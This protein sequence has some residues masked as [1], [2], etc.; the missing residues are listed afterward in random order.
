MLALLALSAHATQPTGTC[1]WEDI[2]LTGQVSTRDAAGPDYELRSFHELAGDRLLARAE[3][4]CQVTSGNLRCRTTITSSCD[5]A[6]V[7][8]QELRFDVSNAG[9]VTVFASD[10]TGSETFATAPV[11]ADDWDDLEAAVV[12]AGGTAIEAAVL[13]L[14]IGALL[15]YASR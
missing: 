14:G 15:D 11:G 4:T 9:L 13:R 3:Y 8:R 5:A 12:A 2:V 6:V 1:E 10:D 7:D